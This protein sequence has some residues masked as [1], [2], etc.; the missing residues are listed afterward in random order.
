MRPY[1]RVRVRDIWYD[2]HPG[3]SS[4]GPTRRRL[5]APDNVVVS[6]GGDG[7]PTD[8]ITDLP[9]PEEPVDIDIPPKECVETVT[10]TPNLLRGLRPTQWCQTSSGIPIEQFPRRFNNG[11]IDITGYNLQNNNLSNKQINNHSVERAIIYTLLKPSTVNELSFFYNKSSALAAINWIPPDLATYPVAIGPIIVKLYNDTNQWIATVQFIPTQHPATV[12]H[13]AFDSCQN[14]ARVN[15]NFESDVLNVKTIAITL[16]SK[17]YGLSEIEAFP[18][19]ADPQPINTLS[20][21]TIYP[22]NVA[23]MVLQQNVLRD[24][25]LSHTNPFTNI[26]ETGVKFV[27]SFGISTLTWMKNATVEPV[28]PSMSGLGGHSGTGVMA[29][30]WVTFANPITLSELVLHRKADQVRSLNWLTPTLEF[31]DEN[32]ALI[33]SLATPSLV[34]PYTFADAYASYQLAYTNGRTI[35]NGVKYMKVGGSG[36][37]GDD[38]TNG[39]SEIEIF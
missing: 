24:A 39:I 15:L 7:L 6:P 31:Y 9:L 26:V 8:P 29:A 38:V 34:A 2:W 21:T 32:Q 4:T 18:N 36:V 17:H 3:F 33:L 27:V 23:P 20:W 28:P 37:P 30:W 12:E 11:T 10:T 19:Y 35:V 13:S 16:L 1:K 5:N 14:R 22:D 25:T